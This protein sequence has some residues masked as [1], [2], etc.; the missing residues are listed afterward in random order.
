VTN[1]WFSL[2]NTIRD[3]KLRVAVK[4]AVHVGLGETENPEIQIQEMGNAFGVSVTVA[5]N[6]WNS[7]V[8][9]SNHPTPGILESAIV[10]PLQQWA[11]AGFP[12]SCG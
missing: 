11:K 3:P 12:D 7:R 9:S 6:T 5:G 10:R 2:S 1:T 8:V 4:R